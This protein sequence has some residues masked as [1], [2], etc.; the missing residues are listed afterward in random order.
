MI[1]VKPFIEKTRSDLAHEYHGVSLTIAWQTVAED[2]AKR[3]T[4][5]LPRIEGV[6]TFDTALLHQPAGFRR[7][8]IVHELL[9]LKYPRQHPHTQ[10][11][12]I[13]QPHR[14][15]KTAPCTKV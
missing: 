3:L 1:P 11:S 5:L 10:N 13:H 12:H 15:L 4:R 9:H 14:A 7:K 8:A 6:L 2:L